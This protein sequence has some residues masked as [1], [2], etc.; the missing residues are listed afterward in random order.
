MDAESPGCCDTRPP[1]L[2]QFLALLPPI[3]SFSLGAY[4][5]SWEV[6]HL[7]KINNN[8]I[9]GNYIPLRKVRQI[10]GKTV[11]QGE[12]PLPPEQGHIKCQLFPMIRP[13]HNIYGSKKP[14][15]SNNQPESSIVVNTW[16]MIGY[17]YDKRHCEIPNYVLN[18][19]I[20][21]LRIQVLC[22]LLI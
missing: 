4:I 12:M 16:N 6:F 22:M 7:L 14:K 3:L 18:Y 17:N 11:R 15:S 20:C 21:Y 8:T 1:Q 9:Y 5:I 2:K 13:I 19:P 10:T